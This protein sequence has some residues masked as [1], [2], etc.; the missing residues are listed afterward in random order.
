MSPA[1][2]VIPALLALG[3]SVLGASSLRQRRVVGPARRRTSDWKQQGLGQL[4]LGLLLLSIYGPGVFKVHGWPRVWIGFVGV[5][6]AVGLFAVM[7]WDD[8]LA[9]DEARRSNNRN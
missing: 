9:W 7:L 8:Y 2:D 1:L 4:M 6:I 5:L 3:L